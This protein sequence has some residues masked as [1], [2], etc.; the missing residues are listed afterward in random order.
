MG[1]YAS[2]SLGVLMAILASKYGEFHTTKWVRVALV[3]L[4]MGSG[5]GLLVY[6]GT[7]SDSYYHLYSPVFS[8]CLVLLLA[9]KGDRDECGA[10]LGGVSYP[11]YLNH[12]IGV[13]LFHALLEPFGLR[14]SGIQQFLSFVA[15]FAIASILYWYIDRNILSFRSRWF[16]HYRGVIVTYC[17]YISIVIGVVGGIFYYTVAIGVDIK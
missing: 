14:V 8:I 12:W 16:S 4:F 15:N 10:F 6:A 2:I 11:L 9:I 5:L 13:F 1:M 7:A 3:I 17:A